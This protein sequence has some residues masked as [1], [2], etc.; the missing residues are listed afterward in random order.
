MYSGQ[1]VRCAVCLQSCVRKDASWLVASSEK[2]ISLLEQ[3][4]LAAVV[5]VMCMLFVPVGGDHVLS[6]C[7]S[8][9]KR[10]FAM[11]KVTV[12]PRPVSKC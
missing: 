1:S 11:C 5:F 6:Q 4:L 12:V 7:F 9:P 8:M 3:L 2:A 10:W